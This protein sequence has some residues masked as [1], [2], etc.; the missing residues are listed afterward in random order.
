MKKALLLILGT[1]SLILGTIG[2]FLP[3]LPTTPFYLLTAWCY[4]RS[5]QKL[6]NKVMNN[7]FF[8][9]IVKDYMEKKAIRRKTKVVA[10]TI[11]VIGVG[12]SISLIDILIV[13]IL[14]ACIAV[15]VTIHILRMRELRA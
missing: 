13:K 14:L 7:K 6:Y 9:Y 1:I 4:V 2:I 11:L 10:I 3:I 15:A 12:I 8:G 5:S